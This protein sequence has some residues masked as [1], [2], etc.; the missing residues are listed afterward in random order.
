MRAS[1]WPRTARLTEAIAYF[2]K[3]ADHLPENKIINANA[4][5][6]FML[7]MKK[8]GVNKDQLAQAKTYLDRVRKIDESYVDYRHVA[9]HVP[10]ARR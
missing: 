5:Q 6:V 4:A 2:E 7:Y 8:N 1:N 9:G 3:A 10:R